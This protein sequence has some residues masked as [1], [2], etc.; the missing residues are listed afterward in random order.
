MVYY[1]IQF[2]NLLGES[3]H[4]RAGMHT[5]EHT[6]LVLKNKVFLPIPRE[7]EQH[8]LPIDR[9]L[10]FTVRHQILGVGSIE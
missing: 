5:L 7:F 6:P 1:D 2:D 4:E 10:R 9:T 8:F 3:G